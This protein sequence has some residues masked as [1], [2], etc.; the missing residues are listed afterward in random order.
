MRTDHL[1]LVQFHGSP[2]RET[3]EQDGAIATL[4]DLKRQGKVRFI[5][6]SGTLPNLPGQID[7]AVFDAFQIPYSAVQREH[8]ELISRAA[9]AGAGTII[10]GGAARGAPSAEKDWAIRRLPEVPAERP[11]SLWEQAKLDDLVGDGDRMEFTLRF[12]FSHPYMDT[13]IVG[14]TSP[15]HLKAKLD[16]LR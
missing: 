14:T 13:T 5:G 7:M 10:R 9:R 12:T 2:S 6:M 8:E 3:L 4:L 1:D 16:A 11:R 15:Q